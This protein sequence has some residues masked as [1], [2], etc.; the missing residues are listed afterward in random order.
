MAPIQME[1]DH[2]YEMTQNPEGF[3]CCRGEHYSAHFRDSHCFRVNMSL[4]SDLFII[5]STFNSKIMI[6]LQLI[7]TIHI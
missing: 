5:Y 4:Y 6:D 1:K 3:C 7:N 2:D